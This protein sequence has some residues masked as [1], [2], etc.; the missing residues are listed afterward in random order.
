MMPR[1]RLQAVPPRRAKPKFRLIIEFI[2]S[3]CHEVTRTYTAAADEEYGDLVGEEGEH[4]HVYD[5]QANTDALLD[6]AGAVQARYKYTAF[7]EVSAVSVDG[8]PWSA[9]DWPD[10]PPDLTTHMLAGG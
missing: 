1:L 3:A 2:V 5:A 8:G 7:G 9:V 10:L 4:A 6:E